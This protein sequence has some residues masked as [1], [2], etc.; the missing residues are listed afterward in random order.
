MKSSH[1]AM[2]L[3]KKSPVL[4]DDLPFSSVIAALESSLQIWRQ[5][6]DGELKFGP[7][8]I[9]R[10]NY[11]R[12]LE[13]LL[14]AAKQDDSGEEFRSVLKKHF[15]IFEVYGGEDWGRVFITSYFEPIIEGAIK[16]QGSFTQPLLSVPRDM[17]EVDLVSFEKM[18]PQLSV[19]N[20]SRFEQRSARNILRG[21]L[22]DVGARMKVIGMPDRREIDGGA[23]KSQASV[24]AWVDPIDAFFLEIQGSGVVRLKNGREMR[25]SYA[26]QNGHAYVPIGRFLFDKIPKENMSIQSI[27]DHLRSLPIEQAK[28]IMYMNP[29]YVFFQ[30]VAG[31]GKTY[32]GSEVIA[33]RTIATDQDLFPKG[34]LAFI[35][36]E[37]P[38]FANQ[39][40]ILPSSWRPSSRFVVDHDTGGAI[41]GPHRVD[42]FWGRGS[43]AKRHAGV[44]KNPGR[45]YY[46]VPRED[47]IRNAGL[48]GSQIGFAPERRSDQPQD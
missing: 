15:E 17:V 4:G 20:S 40:D 3:A 37:F 32:F 29:S 11:V 35:E 25:L 33:G 9:S 8:T 10:S 31:A 34:T 18:R 22:V 21:R 14:D 24:L 47:F 12:S 6:S 5:R 27:E 1:Q 2:R 41:R 36:F 13:V 19:L 30:K 44:M 46:F 42:L 48:G 28:E 43:E 7:R 39:S 45:L 16:S 38:V 23:I 26:G